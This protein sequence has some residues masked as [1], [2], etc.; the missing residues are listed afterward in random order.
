MASK[1]DE[2]IDA[3]VQK[4]PT[5]WLHPWLSGDKKIVEP[6]YTSRQIEILL[7]HIRVEILKLKQ[8]A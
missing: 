7:L 4:V 2:A 3:A 1:W 8:N 5:T 6:P